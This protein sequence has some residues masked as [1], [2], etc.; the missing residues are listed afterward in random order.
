MAGLSDCPRAANE[1]AM[2]PLAPLGPIVTALRSHRSAVALMVIEIALTLAI[3]CNLVFILK[4]TIDRTNL[5]T[6]IDEADVAIIQSIGIV[7]AENPSTVSNSVSALRRVPG[8]Q[9]AAFGAPPL[10]RAT[11]APIFL[12][13][14]AR[15]PVTLAYQFVGSQGY[16]DVLGA[17]VLQGRAI[18]PDET[19]A[20]SDIFGNLQGRV[21]LPAL[22]TPSLAARL[23]S[24]DA[25]LGQAL[26]SNIWGIPVTLKIVGVMAPI[27]SAL[28]GRPEDADAVLAEFRVANEHMGGGYVLRSSAG[29]MDEVL[30]LAMQAMQ[31][32]NPGQ[33]QQ[34][35]KS[36]AR[37]RD[38]YFQND[39][40][41]AK[42]IL[43][44]VAVLLSVTALGM[45]GLAAFWVQQRTKQIGIRRA[46]GATRA[47]ILR[48]FQV[49]NFLIV[50]VGVT[51]GAIMAFA[52]NAL[53]MRRFEIE[54]LGISTVL[55][56][57]VVIWALGQLAILGPALRAASIEPVVATRSA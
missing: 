28:T 41:T 57:M 1:V 32:A 2:K 12:S 6:G 5:S 39:R 43:V 52:L 36:V 53:L 3:L 21:Q 44:L 54:R 38:E 30:P 40:T 16:S 7:G 47:D 42:L 8:V 4:E 37:L 24:G 15:Q 29:Q 56:G 31:K 25:S 10:W 19:P 55:I 17:R 35:V 46:L 14:D 50:S 23:R 13:P 9:A 45:G 11:L 48:Y 26:Y 34:D 20:I 27:R 49:E 18:A 33:V 51:L 22:V